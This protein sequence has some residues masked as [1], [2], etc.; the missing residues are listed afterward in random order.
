MDA[1]NTADGRNPV[2]PGMCKTLKNNVINYLSTGAGF[3][4]AAVDLIEMR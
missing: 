3:L 1:Q 4:P 2:A